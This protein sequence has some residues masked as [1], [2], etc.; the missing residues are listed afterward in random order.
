MKRALA[1]LLFLLAGAP[2]FAQPAAPAHEARHE[3]RF[4]KLTAK[5]GLD[6]A[7]A[8][9]VKATFEKYRAQ[10]A[11]LRTQMHE[12]RT[13]LEAE[14]ANAQPNQQRISQLTDQLTRN[15]QEMQAVH[16]KKSA[17]LKSQLTP[18]QYARLMLSRHG[19]HHGR[20]FKKDLQPAK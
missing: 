3:A 15:R 1:P 14:L 11:P 13:A 20:H 4:G 18:S 10:T 16:A 5:L 2:A 6:E 8:A 7:A 19:H 12:T 9:R 17:E